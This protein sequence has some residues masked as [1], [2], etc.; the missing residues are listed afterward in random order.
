MK[1]KAAIFDMDGLLVDSEI[2]WGQLG[3]KIWPQMG[4]AYTK[5]L[6][7]DI[8]GL[9]LRDTSKLIKQKYHHGL[10]AAK[11]R[12]IFVSYR[13]EVYWEKSK[14]LKG[15]VEL[16][17]FLDKQGMHIALGSST[18]LQ[19]IDLV[20]DR[21]GLRKF[22]TVIVSASRM[23][24]KPNPGV[25]RKVMKTLKVKPKDAVIFEDSMHGVTA[26]K[27]SGAKVIAVP[28]KRW[29]HGDFSSA[30]LIAK[31]LADKKIYKFLGIK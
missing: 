15:V 2:Y 28:D 27:A 13:K 3:S 8:L 12:R 30:D 7:R 5:E 29:S 23:K 11:V 24:G 26:G 31:S 19:S 6:A 22:F 25:Y 20:L 18:S 14:L 17:E 16:L 4:V 1:F 10:S 21:H 9:N